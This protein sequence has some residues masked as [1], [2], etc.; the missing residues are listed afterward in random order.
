LLARIA[1]LQDGVVTLEQAWSAG[2]VT[3]D[4]RRLCRAGRWR[5]LSRATYLTRPE[6]MDPTLRRAQIRAAVASFGPDAVAVLSTAAELLGLAGVRPSSR[7]HVSL[8]GRR[9]RPGR[10]NEPLIRAHQLVIPRTQTGHVDGITVTSPLRTVADLLLRVDRSTAVSLVDSALNARLI[11]EDDLLA[12]PALLRGRRGAVAARGYLAEADGRAQSPLETR[13][14]LR[15]VDG[16]VRPETLQ[17]EIRDSSGLLLGIADMAWPSADLL[18]EADGRGPHGTPEAVFADRRRQN[19]L[20]NA[21]WPILRFTWKD[22]LNPD[23]IPFMVRAALRS[24][25]VDHEVGGTKWAR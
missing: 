4:I 2:L 20:V 25:A 23:Y 1:V 17:H 16:G 12:V 15:C 24:R 13:V 3:E 22:T 11:T 6:V 14:R 7:I 5:R 8:P 21:G 9:A 19:R 18:A 10:V